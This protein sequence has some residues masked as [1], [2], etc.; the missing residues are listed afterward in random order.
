M[1]ELICGFPLK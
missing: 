1:S